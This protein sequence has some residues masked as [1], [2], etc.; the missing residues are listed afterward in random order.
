MA[1]QAHIACP[2]VPKP[3]LTLTI[4][5]NTPP[6]RHEFSSSLIIYLP[7]LAEAGCILIDYQL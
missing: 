5:G 7:F 4:N 2:R 6:L 1:H 3:F